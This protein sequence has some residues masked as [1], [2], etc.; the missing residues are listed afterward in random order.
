MAMV[1]AIAT[2][3]STRTDDAPLAVE[4]TFLGA[5]EYISEPNRDHLARTGGPHRL[6]PGGPPRGRRISSSLSTPTPRNQPDVRVWKRDLVEMYGPEDARG[7]PCPWSE[8]IWDQETGEYLGRRGSC[9]VNTC[10]SCLRTKVS[11]LTKDLA[12]A[13]PQVLLTLTGLTPDWDCIQPTLVEF[14]RRLGRKG[15]CW[16]WCHY[17]ERNPRSPG[18][19]LHAW[20]TGDVPSPSAM[21]DV[22]ASMTSKF[23][24]KYSIGTVVLQKPVTHHRNLGYMWKAPTHNVEGLWDSRTLNGE[25]CFHA[26]AHFFPSRHSQASGPL[27]PDV[28]HTDAQPWDVHLPLLLNSKTKGR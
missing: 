2:S 17:V 12:L 26:S 14:R 3:A 19:H 18:A 4:H 16:D 1:S 13:R 27:D 8:D 10:L 6:L 9:G 5:D 15:Y 24:D 25:Q 22:A 11:R 21:S 23:P 20:C 7:V 28:E